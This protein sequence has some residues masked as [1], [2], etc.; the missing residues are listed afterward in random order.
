MA[1]IPISHRDWAR[2][3]QR[4]FRPDG[5]SWAPDKIH[6]ILIGKKNPSYSYVQL[7]S[8][9]HDFFYNVP[10]PWTRAEVDWDFYRG[11]RHCIRDLAQPWK[12]LAEARCLVY[13]LA[14]RAGGWLWFVGSEDLTRD[15]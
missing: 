5:A 7:P 8:N 6:G 10:G 1:H 15:H 14:V 4:G 2:A 11:L 13:F 9:R 3:V 12:V